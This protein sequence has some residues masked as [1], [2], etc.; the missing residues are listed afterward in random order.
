MM[1]ERVQA[2]RDAFL[3]NELSYELISSGSFFAWVRHPFA[4]TPASDVAR[5]LAREHGVL[6]V[7]GSTFGPGLDRYLRFAFANLQRAA[8]ASLVER[9]LES[10]T[11]S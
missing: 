4:D 1:A 6:C 5:R 7:P 9:L 10:Q 2:L 11:D 8:M 3:R